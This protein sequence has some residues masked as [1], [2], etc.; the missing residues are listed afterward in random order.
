MLVRP[1]IIDPFF[2]KMTVVEEENSYHGKIYFAP[3]KTDIDIRIYP[4]SS[5]PTEKHRSFYKEIEQKYSDH[6]DA[7]LIFIENE[8]LKQNKTFRIIN[9]SKEFELMGISIQKADN[10][11]TIWELEYVTLHVS[12]GLITIQIINWEPNQMAFVQ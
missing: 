7:V 4:K 3:L 10:T 2:G 9:F 1:R 8:F 5:V 11:E 12:D 6:L